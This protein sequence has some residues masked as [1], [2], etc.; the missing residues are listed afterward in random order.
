MLILIPNPQ[1][2]ATQS[3]AA[4]SYLLSFRPMGFDTA[5]LNLVVGAKQPTINEQPD[6]KK[7][8]KK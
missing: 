2:L 3:G 4:A 8:L 1:F 6:T 7:P 5:I